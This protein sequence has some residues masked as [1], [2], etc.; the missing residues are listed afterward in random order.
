[1]ASNTW[2]VTEM[3]DQTGRIAV[4][5]G[6]NTGLGFDTAAGLAARG[7]SVVIAVRDVE[8]GEDAAAR[9]IATSPGADV[10]VQP[11][12]LSS[13]NSVRAGRR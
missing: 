1:M 13:L 5:T 2:T 8:K 11:L 3:P 6:A 12:D 9:I 4:V 10:A 7:A